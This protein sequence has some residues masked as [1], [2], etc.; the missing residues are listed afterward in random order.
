MK[1]HLKFGVR[2]ILTLAVYR[3]VKSTLLGMTAETS[4]IRAFANQWLP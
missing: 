2:V 3:V 1:E 4:P